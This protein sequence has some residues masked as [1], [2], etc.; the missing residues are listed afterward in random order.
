MR[1]YFSSIR[2]RCSAYRRRT[3]TYA[4]N[5]EG[6]QRSLDVLR[7]VHNWVRPH[8]SLGK[9]ITLAIYVFEIRP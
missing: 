4:K 6:L 5:V 7:L 1:R 3:N 8:S 2:R 9:E